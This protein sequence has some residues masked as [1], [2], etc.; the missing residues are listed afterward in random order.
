MRR[1]T[2]RSPRKRANHLLDGLPQA[3]SMTNGK[4]K[5]CC[6]SRFGAIFMA[7]CALPSVT[8][9]GNYATCILDKMPGVQNDATAIATN[10]LCLEKYPL[11]L[12]EVEQGSGRGMLSFDSGSECAA[13]KGASTPSRVGGSAINVSCFKLYD[14]PKPFN[15]WD[16]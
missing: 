5:P 12:R 10:R 11:G 8:F 15:P 1:A 16:E 2:I 9:A 4:F 6:I 13:K 7:L 3:K 14:K